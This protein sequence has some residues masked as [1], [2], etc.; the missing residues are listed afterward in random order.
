MLLADGYTTVNQ[1][2]VF[3]R[4]LR[5]HWSLIGS[6]IPLAHMWLTVYFKSSDCMR[7]N[8]NSIHKEM[9]VCLCLTGF[10]HDL[11]PRQRHGAH[12]EPDW[13]DAAAVSLGWLSAVPGSDAA[14][15]PSW[16][17]GHQKQ[18]GGKLVIGRGTSECVK[19][20]ISEQAAHFQPQPQRLCHARDYLRFFSAAHSSLHQSGFSDIWLE[21]WLQMWDYLITVI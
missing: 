18:D 7:E 6:L 1:P 13:Y 11:R 8:W 14:G 2:L 20:E 3:Y 19:V 21:I 12:Y 10:P 9:C 17:L 4:R 16:L 15:L 5:T